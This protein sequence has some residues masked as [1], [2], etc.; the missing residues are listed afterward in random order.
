MA[1]PTAN[2]SSMGEWRRRRVVALGVVALATALWRQ[3]GDV[4]T[5]GPTDFAA[6][7]VSYDDHGSVAEFPVLDPAGRQ[8]R[9]ATWRVGTAGSNC[10]EVYVT[11]TAGGRLAGFG[12]TYPVF[13]DDRGATWTEVQTTVPLLNGEGAIVAAPGGDIVGIG[14]D[15]YSGD[16]LQGFKYDGETGEWRYAETVLHQPFFDRPWIAVVKGPF[17]YAGGTAPYAT[18]VMSN[19]HSSFLDVVYISYDGLT[20]TTPSA[21]QVEALAGADDSRDLADPGDADLDYIQP[22]HDAGLTTLA[23][24]GLLDPDGSFSALCPV[25]VLAEDAR[26]HC[27][28]GD[29]DRLKPH[30]V[31]DSR[32][33]LHD[34]EVVDGELLYRT[35]SDGGQSW[36]ET[37]LHAPTGGAF[38]DFTVVDV[39][40]HGGLRRAA[41][42]AHVGNGETHQD[43]VIVLDVAATPTL[44]ETYLVGR[45]DVSSLAGVDKDVRFDFATVAFLPD[46]RLATSFLDS[47]APYPQLAVQQR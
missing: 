6:R 27:F 7:L 5:A 13:S 21:E 19:Y 44:R 10:C 18:V 15:A 47:S 33:W 16:H 45:G 14:W 1:A 34:T 41:V 4:A 31:V 42:A 37:Y 35:S 32:G 29:V 2:R 28:A 36:S 22:H 12:G 25:T 38:D 39:K 9:T 3:P 11:S 24:S 46:G 40:V 23:G 26:W 17:S 43:M 8:I 20:Y 30:T